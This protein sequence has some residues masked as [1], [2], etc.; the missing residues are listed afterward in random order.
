M[1]RRPALRLRTSR[2]PKGDD[3]AKRLF[4]FHLATHAREVGQAQ[5]EYPFS[6]GEGRQ[7]R[8]DFAL[9]HLGLGIEINGGI[10]T[11]GAHGHPSDILRNMEKTNLAAALG[12]RV[13]AFSP[14]QVKNGLALA[15]TLATV[16]R[17]GRMLCDLNTTAPNPFLIDTSKSYASRLPALPGVAKRKRG[18]RSYSEQPAYKPRS[19]SG[20]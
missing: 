4:G 8:F 7:F 15:F 3:E 14:E 17:L 12:W 13:L 2:A 1:A 10:W 9:V 16:E 11:K 20:P 19:A 6:A 5:E 18:W